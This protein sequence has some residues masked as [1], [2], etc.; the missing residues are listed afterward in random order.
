MTDSAAR[1]AR[2]APSRQRSASSA[3]LQA[4]ATAVSVAPLAGSMVRW[5]SVAPCSPAPSVRSPVRK[6]PSTVR[7]APTRSR[8]SEPTSVGRDGAGATIRQRGRVGVKATVGAA[9]RSEVSR[10]ISTS[11][12]PGSE[13]SASRPRAVTSAS[14]AGKAAARVATTAGPGTSA[15]LTVITTRASWLMAAS[16]ASAPRDPPRARCHVARSVPAAA[17]PAPS[18]TRPLAGSTIASSAAGGNGATAPS[19]R[20]EKR[21]LSHA[22]AVPPTVSWMT[23]GS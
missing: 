6:K 8:S 18:S 4:S 21:S 22:T 9:R 20:L 14:A 16:L 17:R 13:S 3:R 7:Q 1:S 19:G 2:S 11:G 10:R 15:G 5:R 12:R 23:G